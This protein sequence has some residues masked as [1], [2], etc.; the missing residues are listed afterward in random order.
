[1][2]LKPVASGCVRR[3]ETLPSGHTCPSGKQLWFL[4]D[5]MKRPLFFYSLCI[6]LLVYKYP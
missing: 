5:E 2:D 1:M 4:E 6:L 3:C